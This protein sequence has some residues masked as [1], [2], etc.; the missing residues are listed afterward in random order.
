MSDFL[1]KAPCVGE[2]VVW[3]PHGNTNQEP[4][5][6][7]VTARLSN[8][9]I[10]LYTLSPT[11][12]RE[13]MLNVK[14]VDHP[15]HL[16]SP[17]GLKRW[18]AWDL[19]GEHEK[20]IEKENAEKE[21]KRKEA[22]KAAEENIQVEVDTMNN[23]DEQEMLIIRLSREL[24][25]TPSR[26]KKVADKVGAGMSHQRVNAV[27]RKFPHFLNGNLPEEMFEANA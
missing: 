12:R 7:T 20:R 27:L 11:G 18:G 8:E 13:P 10:T 25:D 15:D 17:Q 19:V 1:P 16:N 3:Y 26:A 23:P 5:A 4:F 6:A 14:H 2:N 9:C 21:I 24:G 22:L